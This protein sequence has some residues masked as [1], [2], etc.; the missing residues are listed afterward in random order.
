MNR[1]YTLARKDLKLLI[2]DKS[3]MFWVLIFPLLIAILFGSIFGGS[4][5]VSKINVTLVDE[6]HS[7]ASSALVAKLRSSS[8]ISLTN[9]QRTADSSSELDAAKEAVRK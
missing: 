7:A 2:R 1:R 6:D 4:S 9:A 8:A 3:A 5:G